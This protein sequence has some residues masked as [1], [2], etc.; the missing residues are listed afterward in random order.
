MT[1][2]Y[3]D[4][5]ESALSGYTTSTPEFSDGFGDFFTRTDGS[6][7]GSFYEVSG[8]DGSY[9]FAAQDL[10][11]EGAAP[12]QTLQYDAI[13]ITGFD[14]I[15]VSALFAE[16][17]DGANQDWDLTDYVTLE[18]SI[19][20]AA[21]VTLLA[22]ESV[23]DGDAFN[24]EPALDTDLDGDGDGPALTSTF[25][26]FT[27]ALPGTGD[28]LSLRF[29]FA[30]DSGDEDIAIDDILV[31][32]S[33]GAS[34]VTVLDEGFSSAAG[35][36]TSGFFS[37]GGYD[38][39][40]IAGVGTGDWGAG[41]APVGLKPYEGAMG[42]YLTGMDL[43][44]EGGPDV[45]FAEWTGLDIAGLTGLEFS[46]DFA[47]FFDAPG[48]IDAD[49]F[50]RVQ[51]RIDG[52]AWVTVLAF[53]GA[54]FSSGSFNGVFQQDT[55]LDGIPDGEGLTGTL[56]TFAA[57]IEGTGSLLD[58]RF[59]A[60]VQAGDEDFAVDNF[61]VTGL[62]GD[63]PVP[64][65][66]VDTGGGITLSEDGG[67]AMVALDLN[68][69]PAAP[70]TITA[71]ADAQLEVSSD[72]ITFGAAASLAL[73]GAG[74]VTLYLRAVDD[75]VAE[76]SPHAGLVT[77]SASSAD[78]DYDGLD[79]PD[80]TAQITD[81]DAMLISVIQGSGAASALE[82]AQVTVEAVVTAIRKSGDFVLGYFLQEEDADA[83]GDA[84]T[85][86]GIYVFDPG[87][88]VSL[89]ELRRVSGTVDEFFGLTEITDV[90]TSELIA[91][92]EPLPTATVITLGL[93][94][95]FEAYEGMRVELI[96][97]GE[98][99]LTVVTNFNLDRF[100]E[101]Q[102]AEGNLVQPTQILDPGT[103]DAEIA[104]LIEE[105]AAARLIIDDLRTDQ[106][107]ETYNLI[108]SGDGTPLTAGDP[109]TA[110]G[111]T[112]RLGAQMESV[113]GVLDYGFSAWR[114]QRDTPLE[115]IEGSNDR[116]DGAPETSG[117]LRVASFN[118]LNYFTTI[119]SPGVVSE[120]SGLDPRGAD[121]P[122]EILRQQAK[123]VAALT[124][125]GAD[126]VALQELE[127][128]GFGPESAVASLV[129]ALN[130]AEGA[131][132]WDF[133][134]PG[135]EALG[136]DAITTGIIYRSDAV[137]LMGSAALIYAEAS[138][139]QTLDL[140]EAITGDVL[141]DLQ[142]NRPSLAATFAD[143]D[144][145][146][147]TVVSNHFKSKG[148]SGLDSY[149][150][151]A[152]SGTLDPADAA[153]LLADPNIDSGDGQGYWSG[154]R[155]DAAAELAAWL[156][157]NPTGAASWAETILL[158][159]LNSY[160]QEDPL[161]AAKAAGYTDLAA[162]FIGADA[163]GYVFDG[164]R[165]TLDYALAGEGLLDNVTG[166]A[167]WHINADEPDLL[168]YDSSFN[169]PAFYNADV[170]AASDHD[171][172]VAGLVLDDPALS[173]H[174]SLLQPGARGAYAYAI[175]G[176]LAAARA[177]GPMAPVLEIAGAGIS[178]SAAAGDALAFVSG[179]GA[180]LGVVSIAPGNAPGR[181]PAG[182]AITEGEVL[183]MTLDEAGGLGDAQ[184]AE[185]TFDLRGGEGEVLLEFY[186][187]G[188]LIETVTASGAAPV[189]V[190]L[191]LDAT[192]DEVHL[193]VTG[194]LAAELEE[195]SLQRVIVDDFVFA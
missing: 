86:E 12:V 187:E 73:D 43:D 13:T 171:P 126:V 144:G 154:A 179:F 180:G 51:A 173:T 18:A 160:A 96:P 191:A 125:L 114:L 8:A 195:V 36:A 182:T 111:P 132:V 2:I 183:I 172:I 9:Y 32:G 152:V 15:T 176:E 137:T 91:S 104:A 100:G 119:D 92:G 44:G 146:E 27:A 33:G 95:G 155:T 26:R 112:L 42:G 118:V 31:E 59:E 120:P 79:L 23:P 81:N 45:A 133:V 14:S 161:D 145:S 50:L 55:D 169:D 21:W 72:G 138:A 175:E 121:T 130:A 89:G 29:T 141:D 190:D 58:L 77:L 136:S 70:V 54:S 1:I 149:R 124:E 3:R 164:Q 186:D 98:D 139:A 60:R 65:L 170:F 147:L 35:F 109:I 193:G 80:L 56:K 22:F 41:P 122:E 99:P 189:H 103:Q 57:G 47:E 48:D 30:L 163:Y 61:R 185:F 177:H 192:F 53:G 16:D 24:A 90:T 153:A 127:N 83:D 6:N 64:G 75:A 166:V 5:F 85:S 52:G 105:N 106:N 19:D 4:S 113:T 74:P 123:I 71:G 37:D 117:D 20:G 10:D 39:F 168:N 93:R 181:V 159:D 34:L 76:A 129:D 184:E 194:S 134:D 162:E 131:A 135:L 62:G 102:V 142:R 188:V 49:D 7:I 140:I 107:P 174:L 11:G 40:G 28:S 167:E 157:S 156:E 128:N 115:L 69:A 97:G 101:V 116:P 108:D 151:L 17:D 158:G 84:A 78:P 67:T 94:D 66:L 46:G 63:G 82:G 110:E 178:F 87:A 38:Y 68:T 150:S 165:G 143:A 88:T 148:S 25:E